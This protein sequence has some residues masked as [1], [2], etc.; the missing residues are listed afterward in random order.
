M[1]KF[2]APIHTWLFNKIK[3]NEDLEVALID[4]YREKY[5]MDINTIISESQGEFGTL[6]G[7]LPIEDLIDPSN[8]HGWLQSRITITETRQADFLTKIFTK[9]GGEAIDLAHSIYKC[10]GASVGITASEKFEIIT[11]P[12]IY[13]ALNNYILNGMPCDNANNITIKEANKLQWL[14]EKCLHKG[15][16]ESVGADTDIFYSLR[17]TWIKA[18]VESSNKNFTYTVESI[19]INGNAGFINEIVEK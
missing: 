3:L 4:A 10:E 12:Q 7:D 18:F 5:G 16:W 11:A 19:D 9:Y 2:L 13:E 1:S 17:N 8:I 6:L 15:Y 14:N